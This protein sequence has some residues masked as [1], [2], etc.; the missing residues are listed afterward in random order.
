MKYASAPK[1]DFSKVTALKLTMF[2]PEQIT[3]ASHYATID[4]GEAANA[5]QSL[6]VDCI[7]LTADLRMRHA[8]RRPGAKGLSNHGKV[9]P[10]ANWR[11]PFPT[12]DNM[13]PLR[14]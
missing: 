12:N 5:I 4:V 13:S 9:A 14:A 3:T 6:D 11:I 8:A 10:T 2:T 1:N 7:K